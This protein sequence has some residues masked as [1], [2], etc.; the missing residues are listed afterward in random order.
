[1]ATYTVNNDGQLIET[2]MTEEEYKVH[3]NQFT[4]IF[5]T[6]LLISLVI[7]LVVG[8]GLVYTVMFFMNYF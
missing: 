5:K 1:M 8:W 4:W 3:V 2:H 7:V 6:V